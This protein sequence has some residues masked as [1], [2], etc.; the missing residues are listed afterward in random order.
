M[1]LFGI[2]S[3]LILEKEFASKHVAIKKSNTKIKSYRDETTDF[4]NKEIEKEMISHITEGIEVFLVTLMKNRLKVNI[5][6]CFWGQFWFFFLFFFFF[7]GSNCKNV[8][9]EGTIFENAFFWGSNFENLFS[10]NIEVGYFLD[11][12]WLKTKLFTASNL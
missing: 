10:I 8:Y 2:K 3:M 6:M 12:C 11:V 7:L 1:M 5:A 9:F 4:H